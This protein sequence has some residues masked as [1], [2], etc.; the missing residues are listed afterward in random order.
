MT[1]A[2]APVL[3]SAR[4][5]A[6]ALGISE[7]TLFSETHAGRL[8]HVRVKSRVLYRPAALEQYAQRNE[9]PAAGGAHVS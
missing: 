1:M 3:Y 7:R 9:V 4:E 6:E 8:P 2:V 5:A